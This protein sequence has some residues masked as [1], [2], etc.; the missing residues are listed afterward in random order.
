M[1]NCCSVAVRFTQLSSISDIIKYTATCKRA[2]WIWCLQF[3]L[4]LKETVS[5]CRVR[6][7]CYINVTFTVQSLSLVSMIFPSPALSPSPFTYVN[8]VLQRGVGAQR[9]SCD[10]GGGGVGESRGPAAASRSWAGE[11]WGAPGGGMVTQRVGGAWVFALP[12]SLSLTLSFTNLH[13]HSHR[14]WK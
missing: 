1:L 4:H 14:H 6:N 8:R 13:P 9:C 12:V 3:I 7:D 10:R 2:I 5:C 11:K